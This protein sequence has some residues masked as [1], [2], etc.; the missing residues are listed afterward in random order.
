MNIAVVGLGKLGLPMAALFASKGHHVIGLDINQEICDSVNAGTSPYYEPGLK[1]LL[2]QVELPATTDFA[3]VAGA[4]VIFI[5]VP[6][7]S[8]RNGCFRDDLVVNAINRIGPYLRDRWRTVV[9][10]STVMP[11][12]MASS[13]TDALEVVSRRHVGATI[14]LAYNPEFIALGSVLHDMTH[15][16]FVLIGT[17][18]QHSADDV[19]RVLSRVAEGT[20]YVNLS[21]V[22]AELAKVAVNA[23]VTMKISYANTL[24]EICEGMDGADANEV[25]A[26]IGR[27]H[28]IGSAYLSPGGPFGGPCF[29]RDS[30]A[31]STLSLHTAL[32]DATTIVNDSQVLRITAMLFA[33]KKVAILGTAYK[34]GT[35]V[36]EESLGT[37]VRQRLE[38]LGT[39]VVWH[40]PLVCSDDAQLVVSGADAVLIALHAEEYVGLDYGDRFVI[41][42]WR[43]LPPGR[44][45]TFVVG[46]GR[47]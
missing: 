18:E 6:T 28:R 14:G 12:T 15:P 31:F 1:D 33:H 36:T 40:D 27:D 3:Y 47:Q 25:A 42:V 24:A 5:V 32:A 10:S 45:N 2:R 46:L 21:F 43:Q 22:N 8:D 30:T 37:R 7:P 29:P 4:D 23:Y 20:H 34:P 35:T 13:V 11:G 39:K 19:L 26:A 9:V 44:P 16:D 38:S 17:A 41:D